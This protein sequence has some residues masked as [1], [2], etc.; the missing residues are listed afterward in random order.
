MCVVKLFVRTV[1]NP[2]DDRL[3]PKLRQVIAKEYDTIPD[4]CSCKEH[5]ACADSDPPLAAPSRASRLHEHELITA[6][7]ACLRRYAD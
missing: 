6:E 2:K 4:R 5:W 1:L 7:I 3:N